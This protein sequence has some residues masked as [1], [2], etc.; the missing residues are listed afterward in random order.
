MASASVLARQVRRL[1]VSPAALLRATTSRSL[2]TNPGAASTTLARAAPSAKALALAEFDAEY[3]ESQAHLE[4]RA[5]GG[6]R[7]E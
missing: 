6:S 1:V 4:V 2:S 5:R 7:R 3:R